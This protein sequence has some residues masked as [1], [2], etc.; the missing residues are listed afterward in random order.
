[1]KFGIHSLLFKETFV[2]KDL[3]VLDK[4]RKMGFDAVEIIPFGVDHFPAAKVKQAAGDLG[5]TINTAFGMPA[6]CNPISPDPTVRRK[7][8]ELSKRHLDLSNDAGALV[9]GG[10]ISCGWGRGE[11][12]GVLQPIGNFSTVS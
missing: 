10:T 1:M 11:K 3:P 8:A 12:G 9:F 2:E 5:Q 7:G 6:E 4:C